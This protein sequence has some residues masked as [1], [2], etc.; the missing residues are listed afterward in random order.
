[1][2]GRVGSLVRDHTF[3]AVGAGVAL[4][5]AVVDVAEA[6]ANTV[7][8]TWRNR[9]P[10]DQS[11]LGFDDLFGALAVRVGDRVLDLAPLTS[12]LLQFALVVLAV[13]LVLRAAR[14]RTR[15]CPECLS[16]VPCGASVCRFCSS[17]LADAG[18]A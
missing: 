4:A 8:G 14:D 2:L 9:I 11:L 15:S 16:A 1:M 3:L 17:D 12:A 10:P 18:T 7:V 6:I 5:L 13:A